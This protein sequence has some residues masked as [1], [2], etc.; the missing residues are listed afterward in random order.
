[1]PL[2]RERQPPRHIRIA[3]A[4]L[5]VPDVAGAPQ[6]QAEVLIMAAPRQPMGYVEITPGPAMMRRALEE[7]RRQGLV[8]AGSG[9]GEA[10]TSP[11]YR[12]R[13]GETLTLLKRWSALSGRERPAFELAERGRRR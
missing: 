3:V 9:H 1:M 4:R 2:R 8:T 6:D 10:Y 7:A 5:T 13:G 11:T 12:F